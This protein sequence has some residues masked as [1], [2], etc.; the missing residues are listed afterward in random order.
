MCKAIEDLKNEGRAEGKAEGKAESIIILLKEYGVLPKKLK[1]KI[2]KQ[3]NLQVLD[4]WFM[5]AIHTR[6]VDEFV[7]QSHIEI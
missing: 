6:S 4:E 3:T 1:S 5:L 2:L 7:R